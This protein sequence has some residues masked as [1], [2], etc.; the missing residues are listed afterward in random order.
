ML[1]ARLPAISVPSLKKRSQITFQRNNAP[2]HRAPDTITVSACMHPLS[3]HRGC[4]HP[5]ARNVIRLTIWNLGLVAKTS[6]P[7]QD[8]QCRPPDREAACETKFHQKPDNQPL[9][10]RDLTILNMDAIRCSLFCRPIWP[11][12]DF[13]HFAASGSPLYHNSIGTHLVF[14]N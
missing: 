13:D 8:Q 9:I 12:V 4:D 5:T 3:S 11:E 10:Y 14:N 7:Y 6:L 2:A 1:F